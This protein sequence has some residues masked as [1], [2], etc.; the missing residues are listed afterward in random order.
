M[1]KASRIPID[2]RLAQAIKRGVTIHRKLIKA[3]GGS[4][5]TKNAARQLG[6]SEAALLN[7]H[8]NRRLVACREN[9]QRAFRFPA[10]QF[11]DGQVLDGLERVLRVL[12]VGTRLDGYGL[13]LFF[14]SK[15]SFLG[16]RRPLDCLRKGE[17]EK[18]LLAAQGYCQQ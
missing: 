13:M 3:E 14:L 4:L 15:S 2:S 18:V 17:I 5:S 6:I 16:G 8:K 7:R 9:S 10:W 11:R 1:K 12:N